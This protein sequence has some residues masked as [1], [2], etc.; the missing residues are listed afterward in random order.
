VEG[1][2]TAANWMGT[3]GVDTAALEALSS[4]YAVALAQAPSLMMSR[5][6]HIWVLL[7]RFRL[8]HA[9]RPRAVFRL[10]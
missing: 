5:Y 9:G 2:D 6:A 4:K 10:I 8:A 1:V 3:E 7:C